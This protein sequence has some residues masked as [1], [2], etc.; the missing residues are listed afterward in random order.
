VPEQEWC[1]PALHCCARRG[2]RAAL[3]PQRWPWTECQQCQ[4]AEAERRRRRR[5]RSWERL[6]AEALQQCLRRQK[7]LQRERER[8]GLQRQSL[9]PAWVARQ[10]QREGSAD[11]LQ[12]LGEEEA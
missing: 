12:L 3:L 10:L 9:S 1:P 2:R 5:R 11:L 7:E 4:R 8:E 6:W